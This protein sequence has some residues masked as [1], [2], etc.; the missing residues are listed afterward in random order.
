VFGGGN[1]GKETVIEP[2]AFPYQMP[3]G[4]E[5]WTLWSRRALSHMEVCAAVE[6][7]LVEQKREDVT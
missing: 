7:W 5:H 2:N 3:D 6:A 1:Q 4:C